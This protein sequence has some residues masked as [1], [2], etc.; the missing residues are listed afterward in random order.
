M[1]R[2][3]R[4]RQASEDRVRHRGTSR[5]SR[6]EGMDVRYGG[7]TLEIR[8]YLNTDEEPQEV[9]LRLDPVARGPRLV[10]AMFAARLVP[11]EHA[12]PLWKTA[13]GLEDDPLGYEGRT[14]E[15]VVLLNTDEDARSVVDRM[16]PAARG[17]KLVMCL[18]VASEYD[19][20]AAEVLWKFASE[21]ALRAVRRES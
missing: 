3:D 8:V 15:V 13:P 2:A 7:R 9:I 18:F 4:R 6:L 16:K 21:Q 10:R 14:V 19:P 12:L 17:S 5:D 20:E 1:N 11:A